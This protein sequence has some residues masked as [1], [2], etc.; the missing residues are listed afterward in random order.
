M[1]TLSTDS[2]TENKASEKNA[3]ELVELAKNNGYKSIRFFVAPDK[4]VSSES[5]IEDA[6]SFFEKLG[7]NSKSKLRRQL[8]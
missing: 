1:G 7:N 8:R 5:V 2:F 3:K 6:K 4:N